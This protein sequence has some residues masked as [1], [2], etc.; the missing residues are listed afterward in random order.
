MLEPKKYLLKHMETSQ[1]D[2]SVTIIS[3]LVPGLIQYQR[4]VPTKPFNK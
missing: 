3:F 2:R 1:S 4:E